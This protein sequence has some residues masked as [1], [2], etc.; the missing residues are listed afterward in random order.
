M[1]AAL[2]HLKQVDP[3]LAMIIGSVGP[4]R[5]AKRE[6]TFET[7]ARSIVY[8][9][10]SG[11]AAASIFAKLSAAVGSSFSPRA[12]LRLTPEELRAC[13]LSAQ[14]AIYVRD[15]AERVVR[16]QIN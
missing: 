11:K 16:R 7:L 3:V 4:F 9:Q 12:L 6:P 14:K 8:Q 5:L 2:R 13:G 15:L 1:R 10:V